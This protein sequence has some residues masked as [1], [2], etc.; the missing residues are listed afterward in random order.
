MSQMI[1][2]TEAL[3]DQISNR[4]QTLPEA[5]PELYADEISIDSIRDWFSVFGRNITAIG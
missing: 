4:N 3:S 2:A 5:L 1:T